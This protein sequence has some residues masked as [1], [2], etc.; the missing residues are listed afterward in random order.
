MNI[1]NFLTNLKNK[2]EAVVIVTILAAT[3]GLYINFFL[4]HYYRAQ[5]E[6]LIIQKQNPNIDVYTAIKGSEQLAYTFKQIIL[7]PAFFDKISQPNFNIG[8]GYFG[9]DPEKIVKKWRKIVRI[10]TLPDTGILK[11]NVFHPDQKEAQKI[12]QAISYIMLNERH[13]FLGDNQEINVMSL[14]KSI[15]SNKFVKPNAIANTF[16]GLVAGLLISAGLVIFFPEKSF[17]PIQTK[18]VSSKPKST[19]LRKKQ[20][21]KNWSKATLLTKKGSAPSNLPVI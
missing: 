4:P 8:I 17:S 1:K 15:V 11:I 13:L 9:Q 5:G 12:S 10:E 18:Q 14:S 2:W 16:L 6:L 3:F 20:G 19:S 21:L 7:S